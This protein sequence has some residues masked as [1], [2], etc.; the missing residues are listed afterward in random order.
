MADKLISQL[1]AAAALAAADLAEVEQGT[2]P[3]NTSGKI[4]LGDLRKFMQK[5]V[6]TALTSGATVT[7]DCSLG[8]SF[9]ITLAHNVGTLTLSN[10]N[11]SGI[12]TEFEWEVKQDATGGRT[13]ALPA[14]FKLIGGSDAAIASAANAVT[15]ISGKTFDNGTTWRVAI[16]ETA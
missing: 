6:I 7:M 10:L 11:G 12:A 2:D 14:A 15:M 8:K 3:T 1:T 9:T 13:L 5:E 4:S 16:Q